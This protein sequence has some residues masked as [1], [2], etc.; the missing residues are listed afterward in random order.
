MKPELQRRLVMLLGMLGS[1]FPG[2]VSNAGKL[3]SKLVRENGLTWAE[4][5]GGTLAASSRR[6]GRE[7]PALERV[8]ACLLRKA[9]LT[10]WEQEF[11]TSI[12]SQLMRGWRLSEK[13]LG[14]I[15]RI[16]E[17]LDG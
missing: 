4:V 1:D 15:V 5:V 10:T 17:K 14:V 12:L 6:Q 13:Q 2:E 11:L 9:E 8:R 16:E 7:S 3:A